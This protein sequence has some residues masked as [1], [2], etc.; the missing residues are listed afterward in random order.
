MRVVFE[1]ERMK[2]SHTGLY[3]YCLNLGNALL[4]SAPLDMQLSFYHN[5]RA[6]LVFGDDKNYI[7]Q[8]SIDKFLKLSWKGFDLYHANYQLSPYLPKK[9]KTKVVL[10]IHDL[11]FIA[12]GKTP[13][14][15]KKYLGKVQANIDRAVAVVAISNFV[16][17]D[18]EKHCKLG[19]K[20]IEVIYNGSNIDPEKIKLASPESPIDGP[21]LFSIGTIAAKKNFHV[22][23]FLLVNNNYKLVISGII[24]EEDYYQKIKA[25][26]KSL[27]LEDRVILTGPVSEEEKYS[28]LKH[29]SLFVFP[30]LAEGFGLPVIEAM[31]FGKKVLLS[32]YTSLPEIGGKEAFYLES[33]DANYLQDF[34]TNKLEMIIQ[35]EDRSDEIKAWAGQ[36]SWETAAKA[37]W[38]LYQSILRS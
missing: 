7:K 30:S 17:E 5:E 23:P 10:T 13:A 25:I 32:T 11:N 12:E 33:M 29:C 27:G 1:T 20:K 16:K 21:F 19:N 34:A 4:N 6:E 36:F 37:Y 38:D 3:Y 28:Y 14:K 22:L 31:S 2:Y 8:K 26:A 18:V 9:G 35:G 15:I 24:Q